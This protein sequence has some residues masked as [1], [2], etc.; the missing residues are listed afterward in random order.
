MGIVTMYFHLSE[1]NVKA[2]EVVAQGKIIGRV[3]Q[4]GRAS[5]PHLHWGVRIQGS[6]IDPLSLVHLF[7]EE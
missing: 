3:G 6:R 4:T 7:K 2:G 1:I 5:G